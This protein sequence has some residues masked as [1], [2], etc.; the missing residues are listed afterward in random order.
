MPKVNSPVYDFPREISVLSLTLKPVLDSQ[1]KDALTKASKAFESHL[2]KRGGKKNR[3][4]PKELVIEPDF[5]LKFQECEIRNR[6]YH[7]DIY[8]FLYRPDIDVSMRQNP[9]SLVVRIWSYDINLHCNINSV[10]QT[11]H[12]QYSGTIPRVVARFHF[13]RANSGQQGPSF[14]LQFGGNSQ[15][16]EFWPM[17]PILKLPRFVHHP[18]NLFLACEF[19]VKTFFPKEYQDIVRNP[20]W[21]ALRRET[22]IAYF[23]NYFLK[24]RTLDTGDWTNSLLDSLWN[25]AN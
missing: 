9:D 25:E 4:L 22:Q 1:G 5:P 13:D 12:R 21:K 18:M 14:H 15:N 19:V 16:N 7:I 6:K 8:C 17:P 11:A 23:R 20:I 24:I 10:C 3:F 2:H